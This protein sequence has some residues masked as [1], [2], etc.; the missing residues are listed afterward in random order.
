MALSGAEILALVRQEFAELL[1]V[2]V[3]DQNF[4]ELGGRSVDA[5]RLSV[6]L[7]RALDRPV[8]LQLILRNPQPST[9]G[10]A[11]AEAPEPAAP[12][13]EPELT[14]LT[15]WPVTGTQERVVL[16]DEEHR[17]TGK[18]P[19]IRT[20]FWCAQL[21]GT[22]DADALQY[23]VEALV[24]RQTALRTTYAV[25]DGRVVAHV[26]PDAA[27]KVESLDFRD[28]GLD[29]AVKHAT[30]SAD[31]AFDR[32]ELPRLR[33]I[34][35]DT[36]AD[37]TLLSVVIDHI[38]ADGDAISIA[39]ADLAELYTARVEG[40]E[41]RLEPLRIT[42]GDWVARQQTPEGRRRRLELIGFWAPS[43]AENAF[44]PTARLPFAR[45]E[46]LPDTFMGARHLHRF[47]AEVVAGMRELARQLR[48]TPYTVQLASL[49][50]HLYRITGESDITVLVPDNN[51]AGADEENLVGWMATTM[52]LRLRLRPAG[53]FRQT[54]TD[55]HDMVLSAMDYRGI[56][57]GEVTD[58]L[59]GGR[60]TK[61]VDVIRVSP[62]MPVTPP[63]FGDLAATE[64]SLPFT[65][66]G[67][68]LSMWIRETD[69]ELEVTLVHGLENYTEAAGR[70]FLTGWAT[71][72]GA[73]V[74]SPDQ[75]L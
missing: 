34:S 3:D 9:L 16:R 38:V 31:T 22:L 52:A 23:A 35:S 73:I 64:V 32:R 1:G 49:Y 13:A 67:L 69:E 25:E 17:R 46:P 29:A 59:S 66:A 47:P 8:P 6:R 2:P 43:V 11:L 4:F 55:V 51:R 15:V 53:G 65:S 20:S 27:P 12:A 24:D 45:S 61:P 18:P 42:F 62:T 63:R 75:P 72:A 40:R 36:G 60:R 14:D 37:G 50:A 70:D 68:G 19:Y 41:P 33:V 48:T 21:P 57:F 7:Q 71:T 10:A 28:E 26:H 74:T 56:A 54:V 58:A 44:Y 39:V 30:S 5:A